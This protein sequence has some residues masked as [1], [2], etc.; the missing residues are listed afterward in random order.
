MRDE[1]GRLFS[2]P[3]CWTDVAPVDPFVVIAAG[4]CPFTP[5]DLVAVAEVID[6]LRSQPDRVRAVR[7]ITP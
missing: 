1:D 6:R 5:S 2:V 7:E 4:R 3:A